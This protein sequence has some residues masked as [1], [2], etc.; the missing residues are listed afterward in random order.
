MTLKIGKWNKGYIY[1][2]LRGGVLVNYVLFLQFKCIRSTFSSSCHLGR[3]ETMYGNKYTEIKVLVNVAQKQDFSLLGT[4]CYIAFLKLCVGFFAKFLF[5]NQILFYT[6]YCLHLSA[7]LSTSYLPQTYT[8]GL[9]IGIYYG[10]FLY[11]F[12]TSLAAW[13]KDHSVKV[14]LFSLEH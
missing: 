2:D 12:Y 9:K 5:K 11:R 10:S 3:S 8:W 1:R 13:Q 6:K 7:P 4:Q 14:L